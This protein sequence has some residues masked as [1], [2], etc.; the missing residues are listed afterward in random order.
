MRICLMLHYNSCILAF[1]P[2]N[3]KWGQVYMSR[4]KISDLWPSLCWK[5]FDSTLQFHSGGY[6][7]IILSYGKRERKHST[8]RAKLLWRNYFILSLHP[9]VPQVWTQCSAPKLFLYGW[10][11]PLCPL[12]KFSFGGG[13]KWWRPGW[14]ELGFLVS[15][16]VGT[17]VCNVFSSVDHLLIE[18]LISRLIGIVQIYD[19]YPWAYL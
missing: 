11:T 8:L 19:Y 1:M 2:E 16:R 9:F 7:S 5:H 18:I 13:L 6:K 17:E 15:N 14:K 10:R 12:Y 4:Q 3:T